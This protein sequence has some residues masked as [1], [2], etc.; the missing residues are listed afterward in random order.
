[1]HA[2]VE[3]LPGAEPTKV[4]MQAWLQAGLAAFKVP[5]SFELAP[6]PRDDS[7]K[8]AKRRLRDQYWQGQSR[9]V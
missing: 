7:G 6:L 1:L 4:E 8:I 5:R 9:R 3:P 2:V